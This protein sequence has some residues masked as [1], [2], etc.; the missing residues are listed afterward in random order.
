MDNTVGDSTCVID[1]DGM[2]VWASQ[3]FVEQF[4]HRAAPVGMM[5]N[6]L[7]A[8]MT[9]ACRHGETLE[10]RDRLGR[11]RFFRVECRRMYNSRGDRVSGIVMLSNV[12]LMK[13]LSDLS[14]LSTQTQTPKELLEKALWLI[15]E[16]YGYMGLA[17]FV[18]RD[19][20]IELLA[21]KGWTEKLKSMISVVPIAPDAPSMAGRSAYH[22]E[23]MVTTIEEYGLMTSVKEAIERIGGE[24]VVVTPL[25]DHDRLIGVLTVIHTRALSPAELSTLE[26]VCSQLAISLNVRSSEEAISSRA[27]DAKLFV[28]LLA[29]EIAAHNSI[30]NTWRKKNSGENLPDNVRWA[31]DSNDESVATIKAVSETGGDALLRTILIEESIKR[32][33]ADVRILSHPYDHKVNIVSKPV[34]PGITVGPLFQYAFRN[35]LINSVMHAKTPAIDMEIKVVKDRMGTCKIEISD[36]GPGIPDERKSSVFRPESLKNSGTGLYLVKKIVGRY[37]G[38]I[39]IEDRVPGNPSRGTRIVITLPQR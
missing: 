8:G 30:I 4:S 26:E 36:N 15:K 1:R 2:I 21:S 6:Q 24:F 37:S 38:R 5:F 20:E 13:I 28:E 7:F 18:A 11:R 3:S 9:D 34:P 27:E 25:I 33:I 32:A 10:D 39:W 31:M 19:G 12:T 22:R 35:V 23:Q 16:T 17:G 14:K 29:H